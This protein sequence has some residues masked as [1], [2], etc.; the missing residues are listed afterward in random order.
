[1]VSIESFCN[2]IWDFIIVG[3][4][5][6]GATLG[7]SLAKKG[8]SVLFVEKGL[9]PSNPTVL[10]G[11]FAEMFAFEENCLKRAG[12]FSEIIFDYSNQKRVRKLYPF[13]GSG[14]GGSSSLF[15]MVMERYEEMDFEK[16]P[17][18]YQDLAPYYDQAEELYRVKL[19]K[20]RHPDLN[21]L[22][23]FLIDAG[24]NPHF[25]PLAFDDV[26]GCKECQGYLCDKQCKN[27][28][29]KICIEPAVKFQNASLLP[30]M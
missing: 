24:L 17:I 3:T 2:R 8:L 27:D 21:L 9:L 22:K 30:R 25:L 11:Q 16:W 18:S 1:M 20:P 4:G 26:P 7:L 15:G 5:M 10:R 6:G 13:L 19:A 28:C 29:S 14:V 23:F 12:R